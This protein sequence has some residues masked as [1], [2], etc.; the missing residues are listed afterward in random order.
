M[1]PSTNILFLAPGVGYPWTFVGCLGVWFMAVDGSYLRNCPDIHLS[2][3]LLLLCQEVSI[4]PSLFLL[5][6]VPFADSDLKYFLLRAVVLMI[7]I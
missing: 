5:F 2:R 4:V 7:F 6:F 3:F 1:S